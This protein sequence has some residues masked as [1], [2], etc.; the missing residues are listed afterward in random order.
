MSEIDDLI[1]LLYTAG[2]QANEAVDK[3]VI[4][5]EAAL[6]PLIA[7]L[8]GKHPIPSPKPSMGLIGQVI[9]FVRS[10]VDSEQVAASARRNAVRALGGI[11]GERA[12]EALANSMQTDSN[13]PVR[14]ACVECLGSLADPLA[15][16]AL[17]AILDNPLARG[18]HDTAAYSLMQHGDLRC[19]PFFIRVLDNPDRMNYKPLL[20]QRLSKLRDP[21]LVD[22]LIRLL[23][24]PGFQWNVSTE[25]A[26]ALVILGDPRTVEALVEVLNHPA[27]SGATQEA[28]LEAL[29]KFGG[30]R[31]AEGILQWLRKIIQTPAPRWSDSEENYGESDWGTPMHVLRL[32][33]G[34][35]LNSLKR[36]GDS[37]AIAELDELLNAAPAYIPHE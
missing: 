31:A 2:Y 8:E 10:I 18:L 6:E 28:C 7:V 15:V 5:K 34:T 32:L 9:F 4:K 13:V 11:K 17:A 1:D 12:I 3:L 16:E 33:W 20:I 29:A 22:P 21:R 23:R 14:R 36:T 26:R 24:L 19:I 27:T 35:G 37:E 25:A 30:H